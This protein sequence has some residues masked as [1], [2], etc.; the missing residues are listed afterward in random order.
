M[1]A[2]N[3]DIDPDA[4]N[5]PRIAHLTLIP[6]NL[7]ASRLL[8]IAYS[9]RPQWVACRKTANAIKKSIKTIEL[10]GIGVLP[11]VPNPIFWYHSGKPLTPRSL[12]II[13]AT[14]RYNASVPMVTT[15]EGSPP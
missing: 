13:C 10:H 1:I 3:E 6:E 8:P 2:A 9:T 4:T 15:R 5:A 11:I 14:P 7:V 12:R